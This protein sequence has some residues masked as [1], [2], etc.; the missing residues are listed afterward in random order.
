MER[1]HNLSPQ[2]RS[3]LRLLPAWMTVW[4]EQGREVP[5]LGAKGTRG[6]AILKGRILEG[7]RQD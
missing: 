4:K 6:P 2:G 5:T 1:L 3:S 7:F